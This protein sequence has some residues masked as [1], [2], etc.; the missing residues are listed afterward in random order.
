MGKKEGRWVEWVLP[1]VYCRKKA[2]GG[3]GG[4]ERLVVCVCVC[5]YFNEISSK[6]GGDRW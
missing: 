4:E 5:V 6:H 3:S 1:Y 2:R